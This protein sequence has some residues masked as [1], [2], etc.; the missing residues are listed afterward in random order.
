MTGLRDSDSEIIGRIREGETALFSH[1]VERYKDVS[2]S[3]ACSLLRNDH[4]A[5][6]LLQDSFVKAFR[7]LSRFRQDSSFGV[8]LYRI[9]YNGCMN[10]IKSKGRSAATGRQEDDHSLLNGPADGT[11]LSEM[12]VSERRVIIDGILG[13]MKEQEALMLRLYY[14][15]EMN[16]SEIREITGFSVAK[17]KIALHRARESFRAKV[18]KRYGSVPHY[19]E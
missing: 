12:L 5:E 13:S 15:A 17:V 19:I 9:V 6:D 3:L 16:V 8:W 7:G 11:P 2:Y 10:H 18:M 4:D 14:L 1:L